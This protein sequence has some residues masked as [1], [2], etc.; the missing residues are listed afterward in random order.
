MEYRYT[1]L[2]A[3]KGRTLEGMALPWNVETRVKGQR[4][5]FLSGA[6][7]SSGE[8]VLTWG[9]TPGGCWRENRTRCHSRCATMAYGYAR[10]FHQRGK[11]TTLLSLSRQE[12]TE[13]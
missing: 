6:A 12:S 8:A 7:V 10:R 1:E 3:I 9:M 11:R 5:R 13:G 4:E 2:P